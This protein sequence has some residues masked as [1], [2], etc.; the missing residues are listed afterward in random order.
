MDTIEIVGTKVFHVEGGSELYLRTKYQ[1]KL[2]VGYLGI[3][4]VRIQVFHVSGL[5]GHRSPTRCTPN[6]PP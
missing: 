3:D 5:E 1:M 4:I 6:P 2:K